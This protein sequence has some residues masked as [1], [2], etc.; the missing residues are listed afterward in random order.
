[1]KIWELVLAVLTGVLANEAFAWQPRLAL[2]VLEKAVKRTPEA[3]RDRLRE[4]WQADLATIPG[5]LS[6]VFFATSLLWKPCSLKDD[7]DF[8]RL[9][10]AGLDLHLLGLDESKRRTDRL[11]LGGLNWIVETCGGRLRQGTYG[12]PD[13]VLV[14]ASYY[15]AKRFVRHCEGKLLKEWPDT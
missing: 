6:G 2:W 5:K 4:E 12:T 8:D 15:L 3:M 13:R 9:W 10:Y 11:A 14:K 7:Q 1:M